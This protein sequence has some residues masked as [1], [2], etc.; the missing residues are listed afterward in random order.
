M[1]AARREERVSW[2]N[3]L[4]AVGSLI[5]VWAIIGVL[6]DAGGSVDA[7]TAAHGTCLLCVA[8]L[9]C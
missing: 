1:V 8:R 6:S 9:G 7:W 2:A 3:L 5:G 4:F